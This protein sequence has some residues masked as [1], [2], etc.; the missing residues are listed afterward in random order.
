MS[1]AST[2]DRVALIRKALKDW[3]WS[4]RVVSVRSDYFSMGSAIR[5]EIK[6]PNVPLDVVRKIAEAHEEVRRC[7]Y[8]GEILSGGNRYVSVHYSLEALD[9][10]SARY[11]PAVS[12]AAAKLAP[13]G[14][15]ILEPV[16]G[17]AYMVGRPD[18]WRLTV[19]G[20]HGFIQQASNAADAARIIGSLLAQIG[21]A[22]L[23]G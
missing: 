20:D 9:A 11:E 18:K 6:D 23:R 8:S 5:V 4:S 15:S 3:G 19:W 16:E 14:S 13:E 10:L 17:T 1:G 2:T 12:A 7:E 22:T 21:G